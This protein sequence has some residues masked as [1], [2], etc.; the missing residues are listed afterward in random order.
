M[1][2]AFGDT[3]QEAQGP[4][5]CV[6]MDDVILRDIAIG[7]AGWLIQAHAELYARHDGFDET[8]EPLVA[9][10]LVDFLRNR[11]PSVERAFI[12]VRTVFALGRSSA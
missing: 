3:L 5:H 6:G 12:A 2:I 10:I 11:D 8:F 4:G 9:E 7:D 1:P